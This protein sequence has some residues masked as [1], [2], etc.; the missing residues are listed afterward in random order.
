MT[1]T[2]SQL[3]PKTSTTGTVYVANGT[4]DGETGYYDHTDGSTNVVMKAIRIE[5]ENVRTLSQQPTTNHEGYQLVEFD[6]KLS[7]EPFLEAHLLD[8]KAVI[9]DIYFNECHRLVQDVT[10]AVEAYP[11]VYRVRNQE[12]N[13]GDF[14]KSDFHKDSVPV[15]HVDRDPQTAPQR[16]RASLGAE[17]ADMLLSKYKHYGS[18]N[19]WRPVKN[20]AQKWPLLL[21]DHQSIS[22]WKY[23]T[24]M[25]RVHSSNDKR[26]ATRGAKDHETILQLDDRYRYIYA[27]DMSPNEAW[28]FYAFHSDSA[29]AIPH[30]AFWDHSSKLD[31]LTRWSIEVRV[32]VFF[33]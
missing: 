25:L 6:T 13:L 19:V 16:L 18:M 26:I 23:D 4:T 15:I 10:G 22:D 2:T 7:Q 5:A 11:Y 32:W 8:N 20:V 33:E 3:P 24:H 28:L 17:K 30:G 14:N 9:E 27:P 21:V 12:K 1:G 29:L 31:A